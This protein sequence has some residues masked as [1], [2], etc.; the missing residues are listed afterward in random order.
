[1][2]V[3][4]P[5]RA[6]LAADLAINLDRFDLAE[7]ARR[8]DTPFYLYDLAVV[9][10]R[11]EALRA[12]LP[13]TFRLAYAV[14]ANP[15]P[16]VLER[17]ARLGL[18]ADVASGGELERVVAAGFD[19]ALIVFTGPGKRDS[20]LAAAVAAGVGLITVESPNELRRLEAIAAS[21]G[22]RVPILLRRSV[23]PEIALAT[24]SVRIIGDAGAGKFGMDDDDLRASVRFVLDSAWLDLH[25]YPRVRGIEP[26]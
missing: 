17:M 13:D 22:R 1:M 3:A 15:N 6:S 26:P 25:G 14:K 10:R 12:A 18:G 19:P 23:D 24:E 16:A 7:L 5:A 4:L 2:S 11:V 8:H 21:A 20:E 9:E